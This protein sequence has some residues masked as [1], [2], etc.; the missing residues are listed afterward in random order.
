MCDSMACV[1]TD[2]FSMLIGQSTG[3]EVIN[4]QYQLLIYKATS[5]YSRHVHGKEKYMLIS[6]P[7]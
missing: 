1:I 6:V 4:T 7:V 2:T 5:D 3:E